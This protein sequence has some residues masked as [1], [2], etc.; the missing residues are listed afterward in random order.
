MVFHKKDL[1]E[2]RPKIQSLFKFSDNLSALSQM[3]PP[4][5]GYWSGWHW[6]TLLIRLTFGQ[7]YPTR[8]SLQVRLTSGHFGQMYPTM[9]RL[10][11][12]LT[13]GHTSGQVDHWSDVPTTMMRLWI[14]LIFG[15]TLGQA[16]H[17][18]DVP[19]QDEAFSQVDIWS[20]FGQMYPPDK[21]I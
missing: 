3:D 2:A 8:M 1:C 7:M 13:F 5:W 18:S 9:M 11:A 10:W 6:I 14:R 15:H 21:E 12:R 16:D 19:L 20:G 4:G 17:W